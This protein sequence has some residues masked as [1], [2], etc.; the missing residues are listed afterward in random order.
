MPHLAARFAGIIL[1]FAPL[2]V[3]RSWRHAQTLLFG[4]I[5]CPGRRTVA[6]VLQT[7]GRGRDRH[8]VNTHRVLSC[9]A[10]SSR[11]AVPVLLRLLLEAFVPRGPVVLALDDTIHRRWRRRIQARGIHRD[12]V[13]SSGAHCGPAESGHCLF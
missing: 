1:S 4:P 6:S 9:A 13:R 10:W 2:F 7:K 3:H 11:L 8:F 12:P 5:L